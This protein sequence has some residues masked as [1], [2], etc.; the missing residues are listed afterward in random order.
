[1]IVVKIDGKDIPMESSHLEFLDTVGRTMSLSSACSY[2][3]IS[4]RTGLNWL[5]QIENR[6]GGRP[7]KSVKGGRHG[8]RTE[9]TELGRKLLES[10]YTAQST[11][12]PG[13]IKSFIEMRL[14]AK[15]ILS[16]YVE[17]VEEGDVI[18]M[19]DV[20]LDSPQDIKSVITTDSL[21]R[22]NIKQGDRILVI[23]KATEALLL[24]P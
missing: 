17:K 8:G 18:S 10:Y 2:I 11:R 9:L 6:C 15:N 7:V 22:L 12:R 19:V 13:F 24:K 14:S 4:Y 5:K 23:I 3:G 16:G 1:M 21:K 20:R